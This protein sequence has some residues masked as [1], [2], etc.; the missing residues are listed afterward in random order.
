MASESVAESAAS[1]VLKRATCY[2]PGYGYY[3]CSSRWNSWGRYV[4]AG[5]AIL[6]F[7]IVLLS[8]LC[9]A[10]RRRKRGHRPYY[11]TGWMAP[12]P[13]YGAHQNDY[14]LNQNQQQQYSGQ[15]YQN[16]PPA[17]GQQYPQQPQ[18]TGTTFNPNDG[19]YGQNSGV[20]SPPV[21][22]QP[23][24]MYPPPPGPPGAK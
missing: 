9:M 20:Q 16:P 7:L 13:K 1:H 6:L 15:N 4:L 8:C 11:G 19:Y 2:R 3:T 18:Y 22:Y 10:R 14:S 24:N 5:A 21:S 23:D 12:P 17:Y